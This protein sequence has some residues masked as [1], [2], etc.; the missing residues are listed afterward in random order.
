MEFEAEEE[1]KIQKL[2]WVKVAQGLPPSVPPKPELRGPPAPG[3]APQPGTDPHC[4][5]SCGHS[6]VW[7]SRCPPGLSSPSRGRGHREPGVSAPCVRTGPNLEN[8]SCPPSRR[9]PPTKSAWDVDCV[10]RPLEHWGVTPA[11]RMALRCSSLPS[12]VPRG[13]WSQVVPPPPL[14][15]GHPPPHRPP[16]AL[17]EP[18]TPP[19]S[20]LLCLSVHSQ[21]GGFQGQA[22]P[23]AATQTP[24]APRQQGAQG[25]P[26]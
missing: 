10:G 5:G 7:G 4:H 12:P 13:L 15:S 3:T 17:L 25:D 19:S 9:G 18:L 16:K 8:F 24:A 21:E 1:I 2:Q 23:P 14:T 6:R 22:I 11:P 26:P 20:F